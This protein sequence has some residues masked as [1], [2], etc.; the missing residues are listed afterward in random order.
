MKKLIASLF[1]LTLVAGCAASGPI[2]SVESGASEEVAE[3][4]EALGELACV[5]ANLSSPSVGAVIS[6]PSWSCSYSNTAVSPDTSYSFNATECPSQFVTEVQNVAGRS[7]SAVAR[8][9]DF[10]DQAT[11]NKMHVTLGAYGHK[12]SGWYSLGTMSAHGVWYSYGG[13]FAYCGFELD[14]GSG[15]TTWVNGTEGYDT[16][17]AAGAAYTLETSKGS[18]YPSYRRVLVGIEGGHPC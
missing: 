1:T 4:D 11:C 8:I 3:A 13:G 17:R 16:I 9:I 6:S 7:F 5:T 14:A 10:P 12:A 15:T 2:D 18:T